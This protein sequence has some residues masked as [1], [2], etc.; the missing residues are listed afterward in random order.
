MRVCEPVLIAPVYKEPGMYRWE[1]YKCGAKGEPR[2]VDTS[3]KFDVIAAEIKAHER[4]E[5]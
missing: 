2:P 5:E 1:C 3:A 4:G